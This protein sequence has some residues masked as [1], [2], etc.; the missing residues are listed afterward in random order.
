VIEAEQAPMVNRPP[1]SFALPP[2]PAEVPPPSKH[3]R[4][5]ATGRNLSIAAP[6]VALE[7]DLEEG[8]RSDQIR[9]VFSRHHGRD[10]ST[11]QVAHQPRRQPQMGS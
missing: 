9:S 3:R 5:A 8:L 11:R 1:P 10:E 7:E 4:L 2:P 6:V